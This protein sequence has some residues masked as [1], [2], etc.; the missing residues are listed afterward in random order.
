MR[1]VDVL[2]APGVMGED[3]ATETG[4]TPRTTAPRHDGPTTAEDSRMAARTMLDAGVDLLL[5]AGG[6]GT[7]RDIHDAVG[8]Q[9]PVLGIPTGVKMHS[10]VFATTA[11][12]A[13]EIVAQFLTSDD[14]STRDAD[15]AD[16]DEAGIRDGHLTAQLHGTARVP[17]VPG[18]LGAKAASRSGDAG[19]EAACAEF[20]ADMDPRIAYLFGPGTTTGRVMEQIRLHGT[21]LGIDAVRDGDLIGRDLD[22]ASLLA[23]AAREPDLRLVLGVIGGQGSLLGRGNQQ[24][25]PAVMRRIGRERISILASEEKLAA[26]QPP[27]LRID[28]GDD[29]LD[30]ELSGYVRVHV[31]PRRE[32]IM[33]VAA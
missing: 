25:S 22:E 26:L 23:L 15:I 9:V 31:A 13:G 6:D 21:L 7:A 30:R 18:V 2:A 32:M 16:I 27:V 12:T 20:A 3:V 33:R 19:L 8:D 14:P 28:T 24:L 29:R 5:F 10:G 11:A 4:L 1:S 17:S